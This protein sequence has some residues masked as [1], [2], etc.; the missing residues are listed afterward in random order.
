MKTY[1]L[2]IREEFELK[3]IHMLPTNNNT[4]IINIPSRHIQFNIDFLEEL[5]TTNKIYIICRSGSRANNIKNKFFKNNDNIIALNFG[6]KDAN[7]V[8]DFGKIKLVYNK[9]SFI[10]GQ[11]I[12]Q[13]MQLMFAFIITIQV[14]LLYFNINKNYIIFGNSIFILFILS[15]VITQSCL[16]TK[17]LNLF[18]L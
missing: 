18:N 6:V 14:L 5:S 8:K 9:P 7:K 15:Q 1:I 17:I 16:L 12:T 2:D 3:K 4:S 11:G 10:K 13:Y